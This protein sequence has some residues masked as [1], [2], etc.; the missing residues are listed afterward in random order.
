MADYLT[1][2]EQVERIK[3]WWADNGSSVI[4]GLIIGFGALGG[5]RFWV[6]YREGVAAEA[7]AHFSDMVGALENGQH[8]AVIERANVLLDNYGS[9]AYAELAR[10]SLAKALVEGGKFEQAEQQLKMLVDT[11]TETSLEMIAR[12]RLAAVMLQQQKLDAALK[13][14]DVRYP[15]QFMAAFE[16]TRGDILAA[17]GNREQAGEAYRKAQLAQPPV[18]DARFLQQKLEDMGVS[19]AN[20]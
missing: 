16:E 12:T 5:W 4:A 11:T 2:E 18:P 8:D 20:S 6:D 10:L 1:D 3:K 9:T 7:S 14:L 19:S 17:Q 15:E 13:V